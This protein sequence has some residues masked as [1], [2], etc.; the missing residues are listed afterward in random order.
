MKNIIEKKTQNKNKR[1]SKG[2][3]CLR[4]KPNGSWEAIVNIKKHS[5]ESIIKSIC[6]K[7][8]SEVLLLKS[9]L[10]ALEP[11]DDDVIKIE[12]KGCKILQLK[13]NGTNTFG[14]KSYIDKEILVKDYID[15]WL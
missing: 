10:Q 6:R 5:G 11:L 15:Y 4:Q 9:Q 1:R 13:Q 8:K 12:I 7:N 2:E 14:E 3:R